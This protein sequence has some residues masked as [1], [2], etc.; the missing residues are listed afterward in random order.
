[1]ENKAIPKQS[2]SIAFKYH[3]SRDLIDDI[4]RTTDPESIATKIDAF[5]VRDGHIWDSSPNFTSPLPIGT[6]VG[7][8]ATPKHDNIRRFFGRFGFE[9]FQN[10]LAAQLKGNDLTCRN[11]VD[12][13]VDQRNKIAHGDFVAA[14]TPGDLQDMLRY[15]KLYCRN[16]DTVVSDWFKKQG[17]CHKITDI[18]LWKRVR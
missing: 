7:N 16:I 6:F 13:I 10:S 9:T 14:G 12:H 8:F 11:M 15:L 17:V 3:L 1:M 2:V 18:R 5:F 4:N